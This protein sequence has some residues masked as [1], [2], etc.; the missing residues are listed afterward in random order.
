MSGRPELNRGDSGEHVVELQR[1]LDM[2][3]LVDDGVLGPA[4]GHAV[5]AYRISKGFGERKEGPLVDDELWRVLLDDD[6]A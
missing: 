6:Y 2:P 1:A 5:Q 3:W 4:T